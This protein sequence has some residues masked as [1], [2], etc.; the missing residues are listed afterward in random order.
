VP[1]LILCLNTGNELVRWEAAKCLEEL[2]DASAANALVESL[3][4]EVPG[5]RWLAA[6]GPIRLEDEALIPLMRG[7]VRD[8][9]SPWLREGAYHVLHVLR[10]ELE[11]DQSVRDVPDALRNTAQLEKIPGA[12]FRALGLWTTGHA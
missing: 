4:D 12:G 2:A 8:F 7:L 9:H 1:S 6:E 3:V 5:I 10:A 11:L